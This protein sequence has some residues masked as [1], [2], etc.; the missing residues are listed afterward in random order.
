MLDETTDPRYVN[1]YTRSKELGLTKEANILS[2]DRPLTRYETVI[3]LYRL[4]L[5]YK[6]LNLVGTKSADEVLSFVGEEQTTIDG[7]NTGKITVDPNL[8]LDKDIDHLYAK[9]FGNEYKIVKEKLVLQFEN[10]YSRYGSLYLVERNENEEKTE[11]YVGN[12]SFNIVNGTVTDGILR[13]F[14]L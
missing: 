1:Y 4:Y 5:K 11:N 12:A 14:V 9:L 3:L 8:L 6:L 10:A 7:K 13:P 2:L